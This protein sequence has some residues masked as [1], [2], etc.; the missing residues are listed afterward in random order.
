MPP[1]I[2]HHQA[3]E[4]PRGPRSKLGWQLGATE[5]APVPIVFCWRWPCFFC[6]D[7]HFFFHRKSKSETKTA[8][9]GGRKTDT[10][11]E[12]PGAQNASPLAFRASEPSRPVSVFR[13]RFFSHLV[14][15]ACRRPKK[16]SRAAQKKIAGEIFLKRKADTSVSEKRTRSCR[17]TAT[18]V[19]EKRPRVCPKN[20]HGRVRK[21]DTGILR[22]T[23]D[24]P[25]IRRAQED[26]KVHKKTGRMDAEKWIETPGTNDFAISR[27]KSLSSAHWQ[28]K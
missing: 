8:K 25:Q 9:S 2:A 1:G 12:G 11:G 24:R 23:P 16:K 15:G 4:A 6:G 21:T 10:G 18:S 26:P 17:K 22:P 19:S 13:P 28:L 27:S 7:G 5:R 3:P 14:S 20:G